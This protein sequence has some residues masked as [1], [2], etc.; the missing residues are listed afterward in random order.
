MTSR[1]KAPSDKL[2]ITAGHF[3]ACAWVAQEYICGIDEVGRGCLAGPLVTAA[4]ILPK[5]SSYELL[6]DSKTLCEAD[7]L[8]AYAWIKSNAWYA[9]GIVHHRIIDH[10][11]IWHATLIAM[12]KALIHLLARCPYRPSAILI[13]AMPLKLDDT[14]YATIP[15]HSFYKGESLSPSIAAASIVAKVE[16]DTLMKKFNTVF[17]GYYF[18]DHKGYATEKHTMILW[19]KPKSLIHRRTFTTPANLPYKKRGNSGEK[20]YNSDERT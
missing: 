7:R 16:R 4:V 2:F 11:N 19:S 14:S 5:N 3:E 20:R 18:A 17:P 8:K 9:S 13:D 1:I 6:Q 12:K 10:H 15:V